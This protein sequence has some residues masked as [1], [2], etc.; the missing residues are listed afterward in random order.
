MIL[1]MIRENS[2]ITRKEIAEKLGMTVDGVKYHIR[3]L[4]N[5]G[6]LYYEGTSRSGHWVINDETGLQ[7]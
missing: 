5:A 4:T 2:R 1:E 6:K 7:D 3:R